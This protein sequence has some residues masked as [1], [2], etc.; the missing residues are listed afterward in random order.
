M[1]WLK[2]TAVLLLLSPLVAC[3]PGYFQQQS[4]VLAEQA[5]LRDSIQIERSNQRLLVRQAQ[6]CLLSADGGSE[7]G[8][9]LLRSIQIGFSGYFLA[10]GVAGES[11]DYLRA[12]SSDPCPGASFLFYIQ[13]TE[14][15][16]CD[17]DNHCRNIASQF[18]ITVVS[19]GDKSLVDRIQLTIKDSFISP[20]A[21]EQERVQRAFE[22]VAIALTGAQ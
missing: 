3:T 6:I 14:R 15:P 7:A 19:V 16:S 21:S 13:P 20:T 10:V 8:A 1:S 11:I 9:E 18:I 17:S 22:R 5:R 2:S 12:M 4:E